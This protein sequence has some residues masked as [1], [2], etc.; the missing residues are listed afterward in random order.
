MALVTHGGTSVSNAFTT[1][2]SDDVKHAY[3]QLTSQLV[4][5]VRVV[6]N[7]TGS[8]YKF[9]TLTKGGSIKN[10]A[11]FED[12]SAMSET[13]KNLTS[14]GAYTGGTA[15]NA[16]VTATLANYHSGE[17][18]D[19]M[20]EIKTN[21]DLRTTFAEAIGGALARAADQAI[22]DA[23]DASTPTN[24]KT[25]AQGANGL[26]KAALLEVHEAMNALSVPSNDRALIISPAA[27]TDILTDTTLVS[28]T[29]GQ[30]SNQALATGFLPNIFGFSVIVSN[31]LTADSVVRKCYAIQK[32]AV[33]L[34]V[35]KDVTTR[36][37]YIPQKAST[38]ILGEMSMGA[39]VIDADGVV[40][41][42]V[43]E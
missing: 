23:L 27:M 37:D 31:L 42:Q 21:V 5:S 8:T 19:S 41:V 32:Q 7:V 28:A 39:A 36:I 34:A 4:G 40:E 30:L 2:F 38:L 1:M 16:Q 9:N 14:P 24:I 20:D 6:R 35:G 29:D 15:Q 26:N 43:T 22:V 3:Q 11:R 25:T 13:T 33:G 18:V 10:K 17:Y 12:I